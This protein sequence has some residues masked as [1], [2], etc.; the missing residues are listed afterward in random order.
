MRKLI[1]CCCAAGLLAAGSFLSLAYYACRCPETVVGHSMQ[2]LAEAAAAIQPLS[3]LTALAVRT[4]QANAQAHE[5]D[6][7]IAECIPDDPQPV[8][9]EPAQKPQGIFRQESP[10]TDREMREIDA[11]PIVIGEED[12]MPRDQADAADPIPNELAA[13]QEQEIPPKGRPVFMPYCRDD[14]DEPAIPPTMPGADGGDKKERNVFT[15]WMELFEEGK[16]GTSSTVEVLPLPQELTP[17]GEPKCQEDCHRHEQLSGC[18]RTTCPF[19][20]TKKKGGEESSEEPRKP[21]K[22]PQRDK[23]AKS[24]EQCPR[25]QG[26][27]TMEFRKSDAGLG[28]YGPGPLH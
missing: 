10:A 24:K 3:G 5:P 22:K 2:I 8:A 20:P 26:V 4:S 16:E 7:S 15:E 11:A 1:W 21:G 17:N 14:E 19:C 9:P 28:E 25:T 27:D 12:P 23:G 6:V 18:P 13:M